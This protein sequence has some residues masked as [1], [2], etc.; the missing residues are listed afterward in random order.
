MSNYVASV[1]KVFVI[2]IIIIV[3][4]FISDVKDRA[5]ICTERATGLIHFYMQKTADSNKCE[6]QQTVTS[7]KKV[8]S[9]Q[10]SQ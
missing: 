1:N 9:K 6:N 2:I 5:K 7:V 10:E 3:I 8:Y 4:I